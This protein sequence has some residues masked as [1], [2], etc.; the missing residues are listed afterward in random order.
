MRPTWFQVDILVTIMVGLRTE[1]LMRWASQQRYALMAKTALSSL[2]FD[3]SRDSLRACDGFDMMSIAVC[4]D[5]PGHVQYD[6]PGF[7]KAFISL[8]CMCGRCP[9]GTS[10]CLVWACHSQRY[11]LGRVL[12]CCK[13]NNHRACTACYFHVIANQQCWPTPW[14][15][16]HA[17]EVARRCRSAAQLRQLRAAVS[18]LH[19]DNPAGARLLTP[20]H[21]LGDTRHI[22]KNPRY[23]PVCRPIC[24]CLDNSH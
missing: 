13:G 16:M 20:K 14:T 22:G 15:L 23:L 7:Y 19:A 5:N 10:L 24:H 21:H 1:G 2:L 9:S 3:K 6:L 12:C 18:Q 8:Q 4:C 11:C 17:S